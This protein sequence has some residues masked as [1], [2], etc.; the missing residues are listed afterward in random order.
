[1]GGL[2]LAAMD[3]APNAR[4]GAELTQAHF[5]WMV[6]TSGRRD[7]LNQARVMATNL[8]K[9]RAWM[10]V[11]YRPGPH[12]TVLQD[13]LDANPDQRTAE[14]LGQG[15]YGI[16]LAMDPAM[17][18]RLSRHF[19]GDAWDAQWP[20]TSGPEGA[21]VY[22]D[23]LGFE[24]RDFILALPVELGVEKVLTKEGTLKVLHAQFASTV[25]V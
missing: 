5:P 10:Q 16:M 20:R 15:L 19:T 25:E 12:L 21:W 6:F 18:R 13:W 22:N 1:M 3:L 17:L 4:R 14:Q 11:T 23:P 8:A 2:T 7:P 24:V 9:D